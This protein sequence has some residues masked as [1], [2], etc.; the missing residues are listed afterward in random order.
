M[1]G[2]MY[3][4]E[5]F[6]FGDFQLYTQAFLKMKAYIWSTGIGK[7]LTSLVIREMQIKTI[8]RHHLT[9][10]RKVIIKKMTN[11]KCW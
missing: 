1:L 2:C 7:K 6:F 5:F 9:C 3:L 11:N 4:L 10:V 8:M